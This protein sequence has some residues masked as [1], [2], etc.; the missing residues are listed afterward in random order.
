MLQEGGPLPGP[1]GGACL[2][3]RNEWSSKTRA[4]EATEFIGKGHPGRE[5]E[6]KGTQENCSAMW[7]TV[8]AFAVMGFVSGLSLADHSDSG[9]FL[10]VHTLLSQ[11]GF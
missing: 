8:L 2:T 7:L 11:D 9:P 6:G 3:L 5:W 10:V 1:K 4:D